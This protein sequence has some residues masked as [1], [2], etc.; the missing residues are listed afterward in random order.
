VVELE[1]ADQGTRIR[2][3]HAGF[4]AHG[5]WDEV[6]A[7]FDKAWSNVLAALAQRFGHPD[8]KPAGGE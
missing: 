6:Y 3:T 8:A 7:Y 2:L 5:H 4:G 1:P